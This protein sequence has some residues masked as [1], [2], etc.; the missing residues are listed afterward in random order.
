MFSSKVSDLVG[1]GW[2]LI[3]FPTIFQMTLLVWG[4]YFENHSLIYVFNDN[5]ALD[6]IVM[7]AN[8]HSSYLT[9]PDTD[10]DIGYKTSPDR[11]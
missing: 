7:T 4:L 2:D 3:A 10:P 9:Y 1:V 5:P 8:G 6:F 11:F